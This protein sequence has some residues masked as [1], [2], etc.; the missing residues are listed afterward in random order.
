MANGIVP[1]S[2][3]PPT[4][5]LLEK[6]RG[7]APK[8]MDASTMGEPPAP[9]EQPELPGFLNK[10]RVWFLL[11]ILQVFL[12]TQQTREWEI[13]WDPAATLSLAETRYITRGSS[14]RNSTIWSRFVL[15]SSPT[16]GPLPLNCLPTLLSGLVSCP[17]SNY[18]EC[19]L[20]RQLRKTNTTLLTILLPT[21]PLLSDSSQFQDDDEGLIQRMKGTQMEQDDWCWDE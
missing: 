8:L 15:C 1:F 4:L 7:A 5:M 13:V 20:F 12:V 14:R 17:M 18:L 9:E 10:C 19:P 6:L 3:M 16:P 21:Q 2:E 11:Q